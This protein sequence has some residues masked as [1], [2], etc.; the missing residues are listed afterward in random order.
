MV[1]GHKALLDGLPIWQMKLTNLV[2]TTDR[3]DFNLEGYIQRMSS[4]LTEFSDDVLNL[5]TK[6]FNARKELQ[7]E[8]EEQE[9]N[10]HRAKILKNH[11][12]S[13]VLP[14]KKQVERSE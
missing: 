2:E 9:D 4:V 1:D 5:K 12:R 3:I 11:P 14:G 10:N 8:E 7:P 6:F 13:L